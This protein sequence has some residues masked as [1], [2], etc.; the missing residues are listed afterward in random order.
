ME[1]NELIGKLLDMIASEQQRDSIDV[2]T[3]GRKG[4]IKVY[5]DYSKPDEFKKK[6]DS[7]FEVRNYANDKLE[8]EPKS[9]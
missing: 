9:I 3:P 8:M 6:I 4:N 5:G 1:R 2:G 7:A